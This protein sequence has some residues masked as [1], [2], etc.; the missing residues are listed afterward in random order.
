MRSFHI[1]LG[2]FT[3]AVMASWAVAVAADTEPKPTLNVF[4]Q[5]LILGQ[6]VRSKIEAL[7]QSLF[8]PAVTSPAI[9]AA[10]KK[11][12]ALTLRWS[13]KVSE[14]AKADI[15]AELADARQALRDLVFAHPEVKQALAAVEADK[16]KLLE[17]NQRIL[18]IQAQQKQEQPSAGARAPEDAAKE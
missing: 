9:E 4:A 3:L 1:A 11:V 17:L 8:N 6:E 12:N 18:A 13:G 16:E 15:L 2:C 5:A 7:E 10:R 14:E